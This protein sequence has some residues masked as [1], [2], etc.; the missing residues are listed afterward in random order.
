MRKKKTLGIRGKKQES[1]TLKMT[2]I[3]LEY[4][5]QDQPSF[6]NFGG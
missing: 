5:Y 2:Y 3:F 1:K 4:R 6:E